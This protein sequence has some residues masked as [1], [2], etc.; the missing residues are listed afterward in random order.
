MA[1][2][3]RIS[4]STGFSPFF[5]THLYHNDILE[6]VEER[7]EED[8]KGS[9]RSPAERGRR[10]IE[11]HR[12]AISFAQAS[13]AIAQEVQEKNANQ[14]RQA[15][16]S[17]K[18]GDRVWLRLKNVV[19]QRPSKK[20]DWLALPYKV[21]GLEGSH[22]V[23]LNVPREIRPVFSVNLVKRVADN[24]FPSQKNPDTEPAAIQAYEA[25]EDLKEGEYRVESILQYRRKGRGWQVLVKWVG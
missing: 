3:N 21:I 22:A 6:K 5:L 12:E 8:E 24:P 25:S 16:E 19:T 13:M 20:L 14:G 17:F 9:D 10:W 1:L 23:R 15:A 7:E 11:K 2:N 18:I 4:A